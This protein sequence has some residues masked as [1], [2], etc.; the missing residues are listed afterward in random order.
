VDE[1]DDRAE[2]PPVADHRV[3]ERA[4]GD[5]IHDRSVPARD[6]L[7]N[8]LRQVLALAGMMSRPTLRRQPAS[9]VRLEKTGTAHV[10]GYLR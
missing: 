10:H 4:P 8:C 2:H 5:P 3:D 7:I 1:E 6:R 9:G